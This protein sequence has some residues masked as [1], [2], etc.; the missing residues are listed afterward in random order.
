MKTARS[1]TLR[2]ASATFLAAAFVVG[3]SAFAPVTFAWCHQPGGAECKA[4]TQSPI[5]TVRLIALIA[6][7]LLP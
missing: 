1:Y 4:A 3:S 2:V 7:L 5:P 6:G